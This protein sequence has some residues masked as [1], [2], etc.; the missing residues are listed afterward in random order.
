MKLHLIQISFQDILHKRGFLGK[1]KTYKYEGGKDYPSCAFLIFGL[2]DVIE[3][4]SDP[5][6]ITPA[7][8]VA[9]AA[10][11][12]GIPENASTNVIITLIFNNFPNQLLFWKYHYFSSFL[13]ILFNGYQIISIIKIFFI[14]TLGGINN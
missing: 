14:V 8:A 13:I 2:D 10:A 9:A 7:A 12:G 6:V 3:L 1:S 4:I 11:A 5:G